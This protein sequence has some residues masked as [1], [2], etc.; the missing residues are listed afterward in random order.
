MEVFQFLE[1][2][3]KDYQ[4]HVKTKIRL[5][6]AIAYQDQIKLSRIIPRQYRPKILN[7]VSTAVSEKEE[8]EMEYSALFF[9]H[10]DKVMTQNQVSLEL[11]KGALLSII[12][13][14]VQHLSQ[15]NKPQSEI[16]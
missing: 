3:S 8:F 6:H 12:A 16:Q 13:Q 2:Q 4:N 11:E 10:L 15:L 1:Q 9:K 5:Q 14:T 7:P